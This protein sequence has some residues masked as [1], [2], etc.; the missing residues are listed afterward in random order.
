VSEKICGRERPIPTK[1][2]K[3]SHSLFGKES[4]I[5]RERPRHPHELPAL[6]QRYPIEVSLSPWIISLRRSCA[7]R[8]GYSIRN[9]VCLSTDP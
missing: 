4:K 2:V 8:D 9:D 7:S 5:R 1:S 3:M 6:P